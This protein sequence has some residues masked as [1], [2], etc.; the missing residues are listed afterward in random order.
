L[1]NWGF[2]ATKGELKIFR[3]DN[4]SKITRYNYTGFIMTASNFYDYKS[5]AIPFADIKA[6][7]YQSRCL[8][9]NSNIIFQGPFTFTINPYWP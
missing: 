3:V 4:V 9:N 2:S 6:Y 1:A 7:R 8:N 5:N